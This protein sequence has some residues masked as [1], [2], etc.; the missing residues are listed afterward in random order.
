MLASGDAV[1][2]D[3]M[4]SDQHGVPYLLADPYHHDLATASLTAVRLLFD[5]DFGAL[6]PGHGPHLRVPAGRRLTIH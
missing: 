2:T 3:H 5:I 4:V 1:I 6:A